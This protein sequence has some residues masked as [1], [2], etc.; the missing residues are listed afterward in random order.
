MPLQ[1][2]RRVAFGPMRSD[3]AFLVSS[4]R[5]CGIVTQVR[6]ES[7]AGGLFQLANPWGAAVQVIRDG[8]PAEICHGDVLKIAMKPGE[9]T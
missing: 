3:G 9:I 8:A 5:E 2:W 1:R 4:A 6:V 7:P